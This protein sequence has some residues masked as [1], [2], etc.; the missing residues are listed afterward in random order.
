MTTPSTDADRLRW[1][2]WVGPWPLRPLA[3][4]VITAAF[5]LATTAYSIASDS[6]LRIVLSAALVG[7]CSGTVFWLARRVAPA[8]VTRPLGYLL[9][10]SISA[11]VGNALR[12]T[13]DTLLTFPNLSEGVNITLTVIRA[14]LFQLLFLAVLGISDRRLKAQIARGDDALVAMAH[15][16]EALLTADEEVRRQV[17]LLLHDRVQAGLIAACLDLR[18]TMAST[19]MDEAE[20]ARRVAAVV[21]QLEDLRVLD[22]RRAVHAL[23]PNLRE[24]DLVT[25]LDDLADTYRPA[26]KIE[27]AQAEHIAVPEEQRLG[28]YRIVEQCLLNA[29]V[30]GGA[31]NCSILITGDAADLTVTVTDDGAG[32]PDNPGSGFGTTLIDTWCRVLCASWSR[33]PGRP[34]M[35]VTVR[36]PRS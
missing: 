20:L 34:G 30:H 31:E 32:M 6:V 17:S 23:S 21:D 9:V 35:T 25:A 19:S 36:L 22:V 3:M 1:W 33:S 8:A 10:V 2:Q 24:V 27:V 5:A 14:V 26:M 16:A 15:Q 7:L 12:I 29:A 18:R 11:L 4:G 28:I 13:T